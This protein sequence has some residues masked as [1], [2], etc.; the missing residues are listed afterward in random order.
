MT[1]NGL[2]EWMWFAFFVL[3]AAGGWVAMF[4]RLARR[5]RDVQSDE[6]LALSLNGMRL[7]NVQLEA[8]GAVIVTARFGDMDDVSD[9]QLDAG[10][11]VTRHRMLPQVEVAEAP[12]AKEPKRVK[13]QRDSIFSEPPVDQRDAAL[14]SMGRE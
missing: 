4:A 3:G 5:D 1:P 11:Y 13:A 14:E 12:K 8:S 2:I 10:L 7:R 6:G 9:A